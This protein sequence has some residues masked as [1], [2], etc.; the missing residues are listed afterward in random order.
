MTNLFRR[1]CY[2]SQQVSQR[3][4][5]A[6]LRL[7][8]SHLASSFEKGLTNRNAHKL[9]MSCSSLSVSYRL[10][11]HSSWGRRHTPLPHPS[12]NAAP[13]KFRDIHVRRVVSGLAQRNCLSRNHTLY[14]EYVDQNLQRFHVLSRQQV[15]VHSHGDEMDEAAVQ[16]E[17]SVDVPEGMVVV[18]VI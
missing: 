11:C 15:V 6:D 4:S 18:A 2:H 13:H 9:L 8:Q 17:M 7:P 10:A 3:G 14:D 12:L 5:L 1:Y 16:L